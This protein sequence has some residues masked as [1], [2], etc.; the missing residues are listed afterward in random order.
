MVARLNP[1]ASKL[2][3]PILPF[4]R[5]YIAHYDPQAN[6]CYAKIT[7]H[8]LGDDHR[9]ME[10]Q[11]LYEVQEQQVVARLMRVAAKMPGGK[12]DAYGAAPGITSYVRC[13]TN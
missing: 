1:A 3:R 8:I 11:S 2:Q 5:N 13:M 9:L 7:M 10:T 12:D 4:G 6:R